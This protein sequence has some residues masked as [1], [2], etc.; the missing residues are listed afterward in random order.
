[1]HPPRFRIWYRRGTRSFAKWISVCLNRKVRFSLSIDP[2]SPAV[3]FAGA[4]NAGRVAV[5]TGGAGATRT[6]GGAAAGAGTAGPLLHPRCPS[7]GSGVQLWDLWDRCWATKLAAVPGNFRINFATFLERST[8]EGSLTI[9]EDAAWG[10][11][12]KPVDAIKP[13]SAILL[14]APT[15]LNGR[16]MNRRNFFGMFRVLSLMIAFRYKRAR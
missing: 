15:R 13:P 4:V 11:A 14:S 7:N 10:A 16:E 3:V 8:I 9:V 12:L 6:G 2:T 1:M 5:A